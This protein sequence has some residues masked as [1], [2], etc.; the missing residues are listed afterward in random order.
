MQPPPNYAGPPARGGAMAAAAQAAGPSPGVCHES[1]RLAAQLSDL[2][3][4][5]AIQG[6]SFALNESLDRDIEDTLRSLQLS[7]PPA[8]R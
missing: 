2:K 3:R 7:R 6:N 8:A 4:A 1:E 5:R